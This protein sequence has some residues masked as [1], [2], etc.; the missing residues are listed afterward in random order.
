MIVII[1]DDPLFAEIL[2]EN[3]KKYYK[4]NEIVVL[5]DFDE[6]FLNSND[7]EI[8]F[9]DIELKMEKMELN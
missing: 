3:L 6:E 5:C 7:V 8:L 4:D 1:D 9:V 2:K